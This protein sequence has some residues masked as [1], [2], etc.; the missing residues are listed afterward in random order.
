MDMKL[1]GAAAKKNGEE[2][3]LEEFATD[4]SANPVL[5]SKE[6]LHET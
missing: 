2:I 1:F 3:S 5:V 4:T 6:G